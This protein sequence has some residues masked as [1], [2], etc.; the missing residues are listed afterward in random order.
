M[1]KILIIPLILSVG[2][3]TGCTAGSF[4]AAY[5]DPN[6]GATY[7]GGVTMPARSVADNK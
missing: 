1:K 3:L 2:L 5:T 4:S 7:H 6:S